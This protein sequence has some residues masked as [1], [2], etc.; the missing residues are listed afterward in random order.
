MSAFTFG[1]ISGKG[2]DESYLHGEGDLLGVLY[3]LYMLYSSAVISSTAGN[4][5]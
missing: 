1:G 3:I 4:I 2:V 5:T